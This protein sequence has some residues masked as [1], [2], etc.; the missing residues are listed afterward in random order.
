MNIVWMNIMWINI[1]WINIVWMNILWML[2]NILV[3]RSSSVP[4]G[5]GMLCQF[6]PKSC[7]QKSDKQPSVLAHAST[8]IL[9]SKGIFARN[10]I[11]HYFYTVTAELWQ[12]NRSHRL[13]LCSLINFGLYFYLFPPG[14]GTPLTIVQ[15]S[16]PKSSSPNSCWQKFN[17]VLGG[18]DATTSL[19]LANSKI[20][21]RCIR[22]P[23]LKLLPWPLGSGC[24][25]PL[26]CRL[27]DNLGR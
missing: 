18:G 13:N 11:G 12:Q 22:A 15:Y 20:A 16:A 14:Q 6:V 1:M 27:P 10:S 2:W 3:I 21:T 17:L 23:F 24:K 19:L 26:P 7:R 9:N 5:A 4:G 25:L 8:L